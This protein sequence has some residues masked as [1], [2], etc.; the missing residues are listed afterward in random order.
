M[1]RFFL[2]IV[3]VVATVPAVADTIKL[4]SGGSLEGVVVKETDRDVVVCLK[5]GMVRLEKSDIKGI[6][7]SKPD[8]EN[9]TTTRLPKWHKC[10]EVAVH[11]DWGS[12]LRH[13]PATV[14]DQ[15]VFKDVPYSSFSSGNYELNIYGDP[16]LPAGIEIGVKNNLIKSAAAKRN[17]LDFMLA[18][19]R[20][21]ED[22]DDLKSLNLDESKKE[23][24][25]LIFE[26]TP[27][28]AADA[29]GAWWI[30]IYDASALDASRATASELRAITVA[31]DKVKKTE[32]KTPQTKSDRSATD[33]PE[34]TPSDLSNTPSGKGSKSGTVYV[35]GYYRKNGTY[36]SPYTR[37]APR[38]K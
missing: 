30:S 9:D 27:V 22:R 2:G 19:V 14:I 29:Y 20:E 34:W 17:C 26:V 16:E 5:H 21:A 12:N 1:S 4:E 6:K 10:I 38:S 24:D 18:V 13:I 11:Q 7:R 23:R 8:V 28:T 33:A 15:G 25:G 32:K 37:S 35:K 36:V 31:R 3:F